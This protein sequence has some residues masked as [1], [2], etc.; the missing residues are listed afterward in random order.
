M[1]YAARRFSDETSPESQLRGT[2]VTTPSLSQ[3][4]RFVNSAARSTGSAPNQPAYPLAEAARFVRVA[5]ATLRT[6]VFG[7]SYV[8]KSG[9]RK[10]TPLIRPADARR[11]VLSFNNLVEA[12]VLRSLRTMHGTPLPQIRKAISYAE[13]EL[14]VERLLLSRELSTNGG[15]LFL[16]YYG[17]L[18]NLSKSGQLAMKRLLAAHLRRVE[19]DSSNLPRRLFPFTRADDGA[20]ERLIVIDPQVGF[21]RPIIQRLGIATRVVVERLDAGESLDEI[22]Q[23]YGMTEDEATGAL[24]YEQAA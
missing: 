13:R 5:P 19:W 1:S 7:R 4:A 22:V 6:W 20:D 14:E 18:I 16:D 11:H 3:T 2:I 8:T 15:D 17:Q 12:H 24:L 23:D 21:G 10:F 9:L